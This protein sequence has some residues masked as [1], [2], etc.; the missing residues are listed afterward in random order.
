MEEQQ[1]VSDLPEAKQRFLARIVEHG[2]KTH[3]READDFV[4]RFPPNVIMEGLKDQPELR[5]KIL[6]PC[7]GTRFKVGCLKPYVTAG[8]DLQF[9]LDAVETTPEQILQALHPDDRVRF[10]DNRELWAS[11]CEAHYWV[12]ENEKE[13]ERGEAHLCYVIDEAKD[14]DLITDRDL[15]EGVGV[16]KLVHSFINREDVLT[17]VLSAALADGD[18]KKAFDYKSLVQVITTKTMVQ[19]VPLDH[20]WDNVVMPKIAIKYGFVTP[21]DEEVDV[22]VPVDGDSVSPKA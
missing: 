5:A 19:N 2:Q 20:I 4:R 21:K 13:R 11:D 9:A 14:Q 15:V 8:E 22:D 6:E 7:V 12:P 17:K 3:V 16:D 18:A 1:F 10:L